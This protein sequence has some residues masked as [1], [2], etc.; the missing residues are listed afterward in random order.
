MS[1]LEPRGNLILDIHFCMCLYIY[2]SLYLSVY[3]Y[4]PVYPSIYLGLSIYVSMYLSIMNV[5]LISLFHTCMTNIFI[6]TYMQYIY[7]YIYTYAYISREREEP[8]IQYHISNMETCSQ[9]ILTQ[10]HAFP[11]GPTWRPRG[12]GWGEVLICT[13][14]YWM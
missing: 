8:E 4:L 9:G 6:Y 14:P 7:I 11:Q 3:L 12:V 1:K 13:F 5:T 2:L 10:S